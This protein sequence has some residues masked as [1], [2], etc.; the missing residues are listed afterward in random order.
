MKTYKLYT[1]LIIIISLSSCDSQRPIS[2]GVNAFY[3]T[4]PAI[5][6]DRF[7]A[8]I[9]EET[10]DPSKECSEV[11]TSINELNTSEIY[12]FKKAE[13]SRWQYSERKVKKG[14]VLVLHGL[15]LRP[16]KMNSF[17]SFF[18][19]KG[20]DVLRGSFSGHKG[21][22]KE[23]KAVDYEIWMKEAQ[24]FYCLS[25]KKAKR[26]EVPLFVFG[27]SLGGLLITD[28]IGQMPIEHNIKSMM[29][30]SPAIKVK[31]FAEIPGKLAWISPKL[32]IPSKNLEEYRAEKTTSLAAYKAMTESRKNIK[33]INPISLNIPTLVLIDPKDELVSYK[34]LKKWTKDEELSQWSVKAVSNKESKLPK[35][36]HHLFIDPLTMGQKTW[37]SVLQDITN[38]WEL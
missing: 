7:L 4:Q 30:I 10:F 14:V 36:Y 37:E 8:S 3:K 34:K 6:G 18:N 20:L 28:F 11:Q 22:L 35:T 12:T 38:K 5:Q 19:S 33:N 32:G 9:L 15:N 31:W 13:L 24:A 27:F 25:L 29:L 16:S 17:T 26:E 23:Q 2:N 1:F 21:S